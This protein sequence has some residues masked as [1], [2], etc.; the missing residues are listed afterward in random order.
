MISSYN[1]MQGENN[2]FQNQLREE[3]SGSGSVTVSVTTQYRHSDFMKMKNS[4]AAFVLASVME[5]IHVWRSGNESS[6]V[7]DCKDGNGTLNFKCSLGRPEQAHVPDG[8]HRKKKKSASRVLKDNAR[9]ARHQAELS[10]RPP[11]PHSHSHRTVTSPPP[12]LL[13]RAATSLAPPTATPRTANS[14]APPTWSATSPAP[15]RTDETSAADVTA[16]VSGV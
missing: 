4:E 14:P 11:P 3:I 7:L 12:S 8:R 15:S 5:F 9:A 16:D 10:S 2:S 1:K 6:L 13:T